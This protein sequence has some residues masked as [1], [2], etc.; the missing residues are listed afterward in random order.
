[1]NLCN[2][3]VEK[4]SGG[5]LGSPEL[6]LLSTF[7]S[8][9]R[10][11]TIDIGR[12]FK[13][14]HGD[15]SMVVAGSTDG[16]LYRMKLTLP[17][18]PGSS[19]SAI[20]LDGSDFENT[21][22]LSFA[23]PHRGFCSSVAVH[24]NGNVAASVSLDG[25][26]C[27]S[28][29]DGKSRGQASRVHHDS[30]GAVSFSCCRWTMSGDSVVTTNHQGGTSVWDLRDVKSKLLLRCHEYSSNKGRGE[31]LIS[32][33]CNPAKSHVCVV[34]TDGGH[35]Y[36]WDFRFPKEPA[37]TDMVDGPV[38]SIVY[39][40]QGSTVERLRFCTENGRIYK[41]IDGEAHLLYEEPLLGFESMCVSSTG[42]DSQLFCSTQQE[43][44]IYITTSSKYY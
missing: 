20:R 13:S 34:G 12:Q 7:V 33:A 28:N 40:N 14:F 39:E 35:L 4:K 43:G 15:S 29:L 16:H 37:Y 19:P 1:M 17:T 26:L 31:S 36:E 2:F 22:L 25:T 3:R 41:M 11:T 44:L 23:R 30:A 6:S 27:I 10:C 5:I 9:S 24:E 42:I 38:K 8:H 18:I 32:L 21:S